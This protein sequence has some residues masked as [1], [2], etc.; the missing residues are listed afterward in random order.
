M[1]LSKV[2]FVGPQK[3][4][5]DG[6]VPL[7]PLWHSPRPILSVKVFSSNADVIYG[8]TNNW[9]AR[10]QSFPLWDT[11]MWRCKETPRLTMIVSI[12][13]HN[14][15]VYQMQLTSPLF[16]AKLYAEGKWFLVWHLHR[17]NLV[18]NLLVSLLVSP[19]WQCF[20][21]HPTIFRQTQDTIFSLPM[22]PYHNCIVLSQKM[23]GNCLI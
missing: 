2:S 16:A 21:M 4:N 12:N 3:G 13:V 19:F 23:S 7:W 17:N 15:C 10:I 6:S 14:D 9:F 8:S 11:Q 22:L 5:L 18:C 1:S 20:S